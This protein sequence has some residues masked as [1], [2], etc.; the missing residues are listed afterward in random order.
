[1]KILITANELVQKGLW[2]KFCEHLGVDPWILKDEVSLDDEFRVE[3]PTAQMLG[4][5][6]PEELK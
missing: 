3:L 6:K 1:M 2:E 5:I 4:L